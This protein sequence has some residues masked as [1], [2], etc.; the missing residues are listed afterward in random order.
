[1]RRV[2]SIANA[3][4]R[5][6]AMMCRTNVREQASQCI[7]QRVG[8]LV[9]GDDNKADPWV[10]RAKGS[11]ST[12]MELLQGIEHHVDQEQEAVE[13][14]QSLTIPSEFRHVARKELQESQDEK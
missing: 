2:L 8:L 12:V 5:Q 7:F 3:C 4:F 10:V 9:S 6:G 13:K 1:M 14:R 11:L